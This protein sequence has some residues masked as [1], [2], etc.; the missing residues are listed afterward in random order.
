MDESENNRN[1]WHVHTQHFIICLSLSFIQRVFLLI[2]LSL[3][4]SS[5]ACLHFNHQIC[6]DTS[7][8][9]LRFLLLSKNFG[10]T[11]ILNA[12]ADREIIHIFK[13]TCFSIR[14]KFPEGQR[15]K[16]LTM[17]MTEHTYDRYLI[18][19]PL[20]KTTGYHNRDNTFLG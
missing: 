16:A 7:Y 3:S 9:H 4:S 1:Q 8:S 10:N 2:F 17:N 19:I 18:E 20:W 15:I 5:S 12:V 11:L 6:C 13:N 14:I